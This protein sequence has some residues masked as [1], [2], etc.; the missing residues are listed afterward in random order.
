M[1]I[2]EYQAKQ[3][4]AQYGV[5][6]PAGEVCDTP[7]AAKKIAEGL[8]AKGEKLVVVKS[9]IHAGGRGKG[10]F[11]SGFQGGVK[12]CKTADDVFEKAK[13][14]LGQVLVT[15]Q[16]GPE[17]KL[18]SKL[19]V[20]G[21]PEIKKEFYCA[22]LL[23]RATSRPLMMVSTEGGVDIEEV[24]EKHPEKIVKETID[25]AVGMMP[26]QA[27]KLA[28]ALGLKGDLIASG[29]KLLLGVYKT[30]W[31]CDAS[32]VE[33]NPLC[34]VVGNDGK[35][36]LSAVDA[37]IGLDDN[38]LYRHKNIQE[39]RDLAEE[40]PLEIEASK[41][42]LNYIKLDGSIAC[43]VNGAGLAMATMDIIQHY[44]G[45]PANFLD[46]GGGASKDQ[47]TA[48][49]KIILSD[50]SVEGILVNIFGGIMDCNVIATGIVAAVKETGLKLPLV[51]RLEGN[52]VVAGKKTLAESGLSLLTGDS[53]ADAAQKVVKAVGK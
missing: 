16:S 45:N 20:A 30:W 9:Q 24:A 21:A 10:T 4:L 33:I 39:M 23:D 12:L 29:A 13:A 50:P 2:H 51:V 37:K 11:K 35:E 18:V 3:L 53:M 26:Y 41:F 44:G 19:L 28:A 34:I 36:V 43:L 14:M 48:A 42:N 32:M 1:N 52:N 40:A 15:K 6:V 47:V 22:V 8:F 7:E 27:R 5:A 31:E 17:G 25:P 46:V 38:A 49:F